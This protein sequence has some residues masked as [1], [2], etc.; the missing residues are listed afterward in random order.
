MTTGIFIMPIRAAKLFVDVLCGRMQWRGQP[1]V[2]H[3]PRS[4]P[5]EHG[6]KRAQFTHMSEHGLGNYR[7]NA[8][9][10]GCRCHDGRAAAECRYIGSD[11]IEAGGDGS[12]LVIPLVVHQLV[13]CRTRNRHQI[14][15]AGSQ[16]RRDQRRRVPDDQQVGVDSPGAERRRRRCPF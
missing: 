13:H 15:R 16:L 9:I 11:P 5:S 14:C 10:H 2:D 12:T 8:W 7:D 4:Q 1:L 3:L 6:M